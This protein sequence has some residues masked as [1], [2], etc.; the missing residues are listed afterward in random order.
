VRHRTFSLATCAAVALAAAASCRAAAIASGGAAGPDASGDAAEVSLA[1]AGGGPAGPDGGGDAAEVS[2]ADEGCGKPTAADGPAPADALADD[3]P[4]VACA[5]AQDCL[6]VAQASL[7]T[8][9]CTDNACTLDTPGSCCG[10]NVQLIQASS[11]DQSCTTDGDCLS[12][13]RLQ[14][15]RG[16]QHP[17]LRPVPVG[18]RE[19][20]RGFVRRPSRGLSTVHDL[21]PQRHVRDRR[22]VQ[23]RRRQGRVGEAPRLL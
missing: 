9:C 19:D 12:L 6:S 8:F 20:P 3:A 2:L 23:W 15:P 17:L 14:G 16:D 13:A 10:A 5:K 11:Y 7:S 18:S 22:S 1:D 21:L 4:V